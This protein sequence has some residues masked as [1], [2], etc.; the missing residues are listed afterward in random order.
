MFS[1]T[2]RILGETYDMV[3][4][5]EEHELI[6]ESR[7]CLSASLAIE[8]KYDILL[9]NYY[10]LERDCL[11]NVLQRQL[12]EGDV[13]EQ[14]A[15]SMSLFNRRFVNLLTS[16]RL[17][18][19][20]TTANAKEC[21]PDEPGLL[22]NISLWK[23]DAY[24][25]CF[26]YRF[27]EALRN[28]V[29]HRGL[30]VHKV[31]FNC[32]W[33]AISIPSAELHHWMQMYTEKKRLTGDRAFKSAVYKQMPEQVELSMAVR[34]Y[35][36]LINDIHLKLRSALEDRVD[37]ARDKIASAI[38]VYCDESNENAAG[39]ESIKWDVTKQP[40]VAEESVPL[41]IE[42]DNIRQ[43]LVKKNGKV[44][45]LKKWVVTNSQSVTTEK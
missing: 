5:E 36:G 2:K 37:K 6:K 25:S 23:S 17:Y 16:A 1:I 39:L 30:A 29:Q 43:S 28:Y 14:V 42:W 12:F 26:E 33:T 41:L 31:E 38:E 9:S 13:Y 35:L 8:E 22:K 20:Q 15:T 21:A 34:V 24:D 45:S 19:D 7:R 32:R 4:T 40:R 10:E 44:S 18:L 11:N 3:I 27:F